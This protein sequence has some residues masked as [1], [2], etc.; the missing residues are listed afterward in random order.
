M[1]FKIG[2]RIRVLSSDR[3]G[4]N[5]AEITGTTKYFDASSGTTEDFYLVTWDSGKPAFHE[6]KASEVDSE[7]DLAPTLPSGQC[8][9]VQSYNS[10][11]PKEINLAPIDLQIENIT[12]LDCDHK[13]KEYHGYNDFY[14]FCEKCDKKRID[15]NNA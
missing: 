15:G 7:W 11:F 10:R 1:K 14:E 3:S 13:W 6:Y 9:I 5:Y 8:P 4:Y 2:D 12:A